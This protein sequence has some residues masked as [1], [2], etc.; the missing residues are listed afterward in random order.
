M[1]EGH[2]GDGTPLLAGVARVDITGSH[3]E[4]L[5]DPLYAAVDASRSAD[6][7][8]VR[9][10]ALRDGATTALLITVDAVAIAEIGSIGNDFLP[11][12]RAQLAG[13]GI[14]P[15]SVVVNAS[16]CHGVVCRDIVERTVQAAREALSHLQPVR[17]GAGL[18]REDRIQENRRLRRPDGSEADVRRAYSLPPDEEFVAVGPI[19]PDIGI[20]RLDRQDGG[21][22]A[23]VY[24]FACH[25]IMGVPDGGNTADLSGVACRTIEES[26][27]CTA[28]FLQGCSADINPVGYRDVSTPADAGP[29]GRLLGESVLAAARGIDCRGDVDM[30]LVH[31]RV[32]IPRADLRP[33]IAQLE[34]EQAA[35]LDALQPTS[36][37]LK[38]FL[39]LSVQQALSPEFPSADAHRYLHE[40]A[41][42]RQHLRKLDADHREQLEVYRANVQA[43]EALTRLRVN[44]GL[45]CMHQARADEAGGAPVPAEVVGLRVGAFA[46]VTFPGELPVEVG[47]RLK[48][49]APHGVTCVSG[50]TNGYLYYTPTA[51]QL[52]NRGHAQEDTDCFVAAEWEG[53]F[54]ETAAE[55]LGR[56]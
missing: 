22:L 24:H 56:L 14:A 55:I 21:P 29:L 42:G 10:L 7:L 11:Q 36:L 16:H 37:N 54:V 47:M 49:V 33:T 13:D 40:E 3:D 34:A 51:G 35:L 5:D 50:V 48:E 28:L 6:R 25:P 52:A 12:V 45:L 17:A 44:L 26:L 41:T 32:D 31:R 27:G 39:Q 53:M 2:R 20:L 38:S 4:Q 43:M 1:S 23:L 8:Y 46:W 19:D 15:E 9:A 18:G 30:A